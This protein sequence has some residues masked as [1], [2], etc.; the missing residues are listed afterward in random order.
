MRPATLLELA[1]RAR[2]PAARR[3]ARAARRRG[4][5][6]TDERGWFRFQRL[7]DIARSVVRDEADV[8]RLVLEAAEDE[9]R[10]RAPAGWRSRSTR[11]S[12]AAR[13]GGLTA[14]RRAGPRRRAAAAPRPP[15]SASGWSSRRTGPGTRWTPG[16]WPGWPRSTPAAAWSASGCPTTSG[17]AGPR[18]SPRRS[19]SPTGPG[20]SRRRTAASWPG[21]TACA[22]CLDALG[23]DRVGHGVRVGRGPGAAGPAR[24]RAA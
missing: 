18:T 7:Y 10:R 1:A 24:R 16:P 11:A 2:R 15:A 20:C 19:G 12:Y 14:G 22:A 13:L 6:A 3:A 8:R 5:A 23:A 4:C 21:R 9:R 17:G